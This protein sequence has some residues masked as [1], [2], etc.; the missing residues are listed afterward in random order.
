MLQFYLLLCSCF[1]LIHP[2]P[3]PY[4]Y[5]IFGKYTL[6]KKLNFQNCY[7]YFMYT[8]FFYFI[9]AGDMRTQ[10]FI[11]V[12][13]FCFQLYNQV[14][15]FQKTFYNSR[16]KKKPKYNL[17]KYLSEKKKPFLMYHSFNSKIFF[18]SLNVRSY[19]ISF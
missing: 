3:L 13:F 6:K 12:F 10:N 9:S 17:F 11:I 8:H 5:T 7:V 1:R 18:I 15:I 16:A 14:C 19:N 2:N 4:L